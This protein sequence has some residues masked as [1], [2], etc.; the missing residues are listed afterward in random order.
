MSDEEKKVEVKQPTTY[1]EQ[2]KKIIEHGSIVGDE[3]YAK[4]VLQR[5]NYYRFSAYFLSFQKNNDNLVKIQHS[6]MSIVH[7]CLIVGLELYCSQ[8]LK[9]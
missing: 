5:I 4:L 8:L 2:V 9:R 7:I 6:T 3:G 1:D